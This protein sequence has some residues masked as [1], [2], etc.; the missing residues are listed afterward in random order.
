M[1]L[2][3]LV[4]LAFRKHKALRTLFRQAVESEATAR[5]V[6]K[7][8]SQI[9]SGVETVC[10]HFASEPLPS[11]QEESVSV[12]V[13]DDLDD[14]LVEIRPASTYQSHSRSAAHIRASKQWDE[15]RCA[16]PQVHGAPLDAD[17][18]T[19]RVYFYG[20]EAELDL[21]RGN[22]EWPLVYATGMGQSGNFD[23][24]LIDGTLAVTP[25]GTSVERRLPDRPSYYD[26]SPSQR[27][28]YLDWLLSGKRDPE[29]ELGYVLIYFYGLERRVLVDRSD[30][31]PIARELIRLLSIYE[32]SNSFRR[33]ASMFLWITLYL[34]S[35]SARVPASLLA[36]AVRIT[37]RWNDDL[38]GICLSIFYSG[39]HLLPAHVAFRVSQHD[40][41]SASSVIVCRHG[42]KFE[43]LF[44]VKYQEQFG[45]GIRL[46]ASKQ[47]K[48]IEYQPA[49]STLP[50][51]VDAILLPGMPDVLAVSSQF[52]EIVRSWG[53]AIEQLK[54]YSRATRFSGSARTTEAY[55]ALPK[56]LQEGDHPELDAW[57]QAWKDHIDEQG[58]PVV[59][60]AALAKIKEIPY[61]DSLT[62]AECNR[63]LRTADT[64]GL[65]IEPDARLTGKNYKWDECVALF[66]LDRE[67]N[68]DTAG[69]LAASVLLR[70]GASIAAAD[71]PVN[72]DEL[73]FIIDYLEKQFSLSER[74]S[75]RLACLQYL[76]LHSQSGDNT[77]NRMLAKRL[78]RSYRLLA[79]EFLVGVAAVDQVITQHEIKALRKAYRLLHL[80]VADLEQLI[81]CHAVPTTD[82]VCRP[83]QHAAVR[84]DMQAVS[85]IMAETREVANI[86][87]NA[88]AEDDRSGDSTMKA[89]E[90]AVG[91]NPPLSA[92][93]PVTSPG[94]SAVIADLDSRFRPFLAAVLEREEWTPAE[95]RELADKY[96]VMIS[97]AVETINEW[98]TEHCG[99]WLIEERDHYHVRT[100]LIPEAN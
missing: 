4:E 69:Y 19:D 17:L 68:P 97:G 30:H 16:E 93:S 41:P 10:K 65:G 35:Q 75:K 45:D 42:D 52:D 20:P 100:N 40:S 56:E 60:V 62:K 27:A 2:E 18:P 38:L 37:S 25:A 21:G 1:G 6:E 77:I 73:T 72:E 58:W 70:L 86:L 9:R 5:I 59:P 53:A 51:S 43:K 15:Q 91:A 49:S 57:G 12:E 34:A 71:G 55:E 67:S 28:H 48:R 50:R 76:L 80:D 54:A 22:V 87:R 29:T 85:R 81:E 7:T 44:Q 96:H 64:L 11:H 63:L 66:Y 36:D 31:L 24:S 89:G 23:A 39:G 98:S 74:S 13:V 14:E 47:L 92:N 94:K 46:R 95:L 26:C 3:I 90:R 83:P 78:P 33:H 8:V 79:G 84:L 32:R 99:D 82:E 88:M 61:C